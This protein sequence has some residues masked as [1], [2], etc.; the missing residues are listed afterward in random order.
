L[1]RAAPALYERG[2][3]KSYN[4]AFSN[5]PKNV[6]GFNNDLSAA[7]PDKVVLVRPPQGVLTDLNSNGNAEM[8]TGPY[9]KLFP[10]AAFPPNIRA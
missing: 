8:I 9:N 1:I 5:F 7:Q 2:Y 4:Q 10:D 3:H 6:V